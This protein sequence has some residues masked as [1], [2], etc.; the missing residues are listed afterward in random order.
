MLLDE[1]IN[2]LP[3][4]KVV[5]FFDIKICTFLEPVDLNFSFAHFPYHHVLKKDKHNVISIFGLRN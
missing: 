1:C 3:L 5:S 2:A 4:V